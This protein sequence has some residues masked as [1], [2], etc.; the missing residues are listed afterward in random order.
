MKLFFSLYFLLSRLSSLHSLLFT[1]EKDNVTKL[2]LFHNASSP[3]KLEGFPSTRMSTIEA[4]GVVVA[5]GVVAGPAAV[6]GVTIL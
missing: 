1:L 3:A 4:D 5:R 2:Q 6:S